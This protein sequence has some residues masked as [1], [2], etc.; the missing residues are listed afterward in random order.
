[1]KKRLSFSIVA[2]LFVAVL[3]SSCSGV[4]SVHKEEKYTIGVVTKSSTSEYWMS[5]C[6]G[7][8][9]ASE[10]YGMDV[11]F[12]QP[13]SETNKEAQIKM[14]ETLAK[15]KVDIIAL[16]PVDSQNASEY[17]KV[18]NENNVPVICYDDEFESHEVPYIG[19]DNEKAG[20]ELMKYL[21]KQMD[22]K[23]E[24]GIISGHLSQ[25]CHRLRI[26]GAKKYLKEEP[27][28]KLAYV[29]SGYSN[30]QMRENE[31]IQLSQEYPMAQ[32]VMVTS[33]STAMGFIDAVSDK[34]MKIVSID[35]Q[36]DALTALKE[37]RITALIAQS[38]YEVG[39]EMV[40]YIAEYREAEIL[41]KDKIVEAQLLTL[42]N[43]EEYL[44]LKE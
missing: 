6:E 23:G 27:N 40:R 37:G 24:V 2:I 18:A 9:K 8:K 7:A 28:M 43:V 11:I 4:Q 35:A 15:K 5:L 42:N 32:G 41:N 17:L 31:I 20:Y 19:I 39:Y 36:T 30:L 16:S 21:A 34:D 33:A 38:G 13:D 10:E 1:M 26:E 25:K 12:L 29:K 3:V 22:H 44:Q 14:V